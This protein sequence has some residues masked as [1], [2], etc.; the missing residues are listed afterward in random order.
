MVVLS[1]RIDDRGGRMKG[2]L[3]RAG[4]GLRIRPA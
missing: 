3:S 4:N 1:Y 2:I